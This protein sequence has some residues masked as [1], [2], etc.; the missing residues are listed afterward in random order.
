MPAPAGVD[1]VA[2]LVDS[3]SA[4]ILDSIGPTIQVLTNVDGD[5]GQPCVL[6]GTIP[7]HA[8]VPLHSH[9]DPET[10]LPLSG[11]LEGLVETAHGYEWLWLGPG[12]VF[13]V[14]RN[15]KHAFRNR[16]HDPAVAYVA[17]TNRMARFFRDSG[18]PADPRS[19][20]TWPP[21]HELLQR[22][23]EVSRRYGHWIATARENAAVGLR[24]G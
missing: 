5:E 22:F 11:Q 15:A 21:A 20:G 3:R 12:D 14:P 4:Q 18:L 1:S 19:T 24:L 2:H 23:L 13:H 17:T 8:I 7:A 16:S 9:P 6:R 10:Y